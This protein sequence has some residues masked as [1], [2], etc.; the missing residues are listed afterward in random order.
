MLHCPDW[1]LSLTMFPKSLQQRCRFEPA[2]SVLE[3]NGIGFTRPD[4]AELKSEIGSIPQK[5]YADSRV[6]SLWRPVDAL[7]WELR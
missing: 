5:S 6:S 3:F 1:L 2:S 7:D 4:F